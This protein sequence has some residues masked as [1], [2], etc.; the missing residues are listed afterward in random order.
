MI[1]KKANW[2]GT[3]KE[4]HFTLSHQFTPNH[5]V[6]HYFFVFIKITSG[7]LKPTRTAGHTYYLP[8]PARTSIT[9]KV[10]ASHWMAA[11][12]SCWTLPAVSKA[13]RAQAFLLALK[14]GHSQ[15]TVTMLAEGLLQPVN[16][17]SS[18]WFEHIWE[19]GPWRQ[20]SDQRGLQTPRYWDVDVQQSTRDLWF[21][22]WHRPR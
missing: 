8:L 21:I 18:G 2:S 4:I 3:N 17:S 1:G 6:Q 9:P 7:N 13:A 20:Q 5:T 11:L 22:I 10:E 12:S 15:N 16:P 14:H 19:A